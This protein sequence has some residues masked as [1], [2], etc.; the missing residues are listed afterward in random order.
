MHPSFN[1]SWFDRCVG[2]W[3]FG[4]LPCTFPQDIGS[5]FITHL[6]CDFF[7]IANWTVAKANVKF[8]T[9][10]LTLCWNS[11]AHYSWPPK[12]NRPSALVLQGQQHGTLM[13]PI[14]IVVSAYPVQFGPAIRQSGL[15]ALI[16]FSSICVTLSYAAVTHLAVANLLPFRALT[17][18]AA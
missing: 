3:P 16:V 15:V 7:I 10:C 2:C 14:L 1:Q 5:S 17:E 6:R 12:V 4:Q 9:F 8:A 13:L 11:P 18:Q